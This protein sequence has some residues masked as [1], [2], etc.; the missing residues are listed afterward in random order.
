MAIIGQSDSIPEQQFLDCFAR[1]SED[2]VII[3]LRP[4]RQF[5]TATNMLMSML[6]TCIGRY[7]S[8]VKAS[9]LQKI[10]QLGIF[11]S[12]EVR[13]KMGEMCDLEI[14]SRQHV[15]LEEYFTPEKDFYHFVQATP[16]ERR[17]EIQWFTKNPR[18]SGDF[19]FKRVNETR[20]F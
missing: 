6:A 18:E 3:F 9:D 12:W 11:A 8:P 15:G 1:L 19:S 10:S 20:L 4:D 17:K 13:R 2:E 5:F 7:G 16:F 14:F